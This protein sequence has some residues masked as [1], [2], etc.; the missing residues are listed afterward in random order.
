MGVVVGD[1][2]RAGSCAIIDSTPP[3]SHEREKEGRKEGWMNGK[4][5]EGKE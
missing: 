3:H 5:E 1:V 4:M 2:A